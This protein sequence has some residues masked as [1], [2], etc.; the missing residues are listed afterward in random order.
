MLGGEEDGTGTGKM[1][2]GG[3]SCTHGTFS[4]NALILDILLGMYTDLES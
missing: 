1:G 2:G 3:A 4:P